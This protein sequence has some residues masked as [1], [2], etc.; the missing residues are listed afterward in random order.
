MAY[1]ASG[2]TAEQVQQADEERTKRA[3]IGFLSSAVGLDQTYANDDPYI[4]QAPGMY[5]IAN[6]DGSY[7]QQGRSVSNQQSITSAAPGVVI[8]PGLL[9]VGFLLFLAFRKG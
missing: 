9:V 7:S 2:L 3:F 1:T 8:T 4:G 6:P 5:V